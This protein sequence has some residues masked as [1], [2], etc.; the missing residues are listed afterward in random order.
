MRW[1]RDW[2]ASGFGMSCKMRKKEEESGGVSGVRKR[3]VRVE[4]AVEEW[5]FRHGLVG[6]GL[7]EVV[8]DESREIRGEEFENGNKTSYEDMLKICWGKQ[9]C[10][11]CLG[12]KSDDGGHVGCSWCP[13]VGCS[14]LIHVAIASLSSN[15]FI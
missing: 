12:T 5:I 6:N 1:L 8:F 4:S 9:G 2:E 15:I 11:S 14:S 7:D 3:E 13:S 10:W